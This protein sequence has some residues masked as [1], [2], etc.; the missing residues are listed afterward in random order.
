MTKAPIALFVYDRLSHAQRTIASL[1]ANYGADESDLLVFSDAARAPE[2]QPAV[3]SVRAFVR[4]IRGFKSVQVFERPSNY[5]LAKSIIGGINQVLAEYDR[6]IV[7]EDDLV[8][9]PYFLSYMNEA[10]ARFQDD[11]RVISVH[12]YVYPVKAALPKAFF[13]EGADCWGWGTWRRG[14]SVF[15][16][17]GQALLDELTRRKLLHAF[18]FNGTYPYSGMLRS[19]IAGKNDSWAIRWYASAF[20][21]SK[22]TLYPGRSLV[23]NIGN[24]GS[25]THVDDTDTHDTDLTSTPIDLRHLPVE[26]S[27]E[28][29]AA[30]EAFF[31]RFAGSFLQRAIRRTRQIVARIAG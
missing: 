25:G 10:L 12:G 11:D 21:A 23:Q 24:D 29:R 20:L 4:V 13:L 27:S 19:Q 17:D 8:T 18:D 30:F 5:G 16:P 22:L 26:P 9:S 15:N 1:L 3:E 31:R 2:H 28:A 6:L 7:L 14:W